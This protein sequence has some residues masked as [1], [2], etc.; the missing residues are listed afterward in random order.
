MRALFLLANAALFCWLLRKPPAVVIDTATYLD[1]GIQRTPGYPLFLDAMRLL[2]GSHFLKLTQ[3]VQ[4]I[5][6]FLCAH[7]LAG[8][9]R[10]CLRLPQ[11]VAGLL[12]LLFLVP[13]LRFGQDIATESL[14]HGLF[15]LLLSFLVRSFFSRNNRDVF[16]V[17]A[18]LLALTLT[19]PQ[20]YFLVPLSALYLGWLA[21]SRRS[22]RPDLLA[23]AAL[24]LA[25][26]G[27]FLAQ[28]TYNLHYH[29]RFAR[30]PFTGMQ[31]YT[32][33]LYFSE[34]ADVARMPDAE[35]ARYFQTTAEI[36]QQRGWSVR[37]RAPYRSYFDHFDEMYSHTYLKVVVP[38]FLRQA[39]KADLD[40]EG[41]VA[42]DRLTLRISA[43]LAWA[44]KKQLAFHIAKQIQ[45][46]GGYLILLMALS[47]GLC[48]PL[49]RRTAWGGALMLLSVG[50]MG[51]A[52][53]GLVA[54]LEPVGARYTM[55][56]EN[57][58]LPFLLAFV[59]S[60]LVHVQ[61]G[62]GLASASL[63][64][65]ILSSSQRSPGQALGESA[66]IAR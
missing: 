20:F 37:H 19:R 54:L 40:P 47:V 5:I 50:L 26:S 52:N 45:E 43:R 35:A 3:L 15:L 18:A 48:V 9:L 17:A 66:A 31:V 49:Y 60:L 24:A 30:I 33:L 51:L 39:G 55:Y 65:S 42:F 10:R 14:S 61:A 36:V 64:G 12:C 57:I 11:A 62:R 59:A 23:A 6:G 27:S 21:W 44:H 56:T 4:V 41:W 13:Q 53:Y 1:H 58:Q 7:H 25:V 46:T 34:P 38:E 22:P 63:P 2:A 8:S 28:A 32:V 16:G 29:G